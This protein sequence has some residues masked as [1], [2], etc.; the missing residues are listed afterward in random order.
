MDRFQLYING[1]QVEFNTT[2]SPILFQRQRTD[3]TNPTIVKNSFT[4]TVTL[5]GT[6]TN[7]QIFNEIWKLDR[8]QTNRIFNPSKRAPFV[9]IKDGDLIEKGYVKLNKI[10][11]KNNLY[12]Y[13]ITLYG[14]LGNILYEL[15]Y[16]TDPETDETTPMTLGNLSWGFTEFMISKDEVSWAWEKLQNPEMT[17]YDRYLTIN[18][19]VCY[20]GAPSGAKNFDAKAVW[21]SIGEPDIADPE[22]LRFN[23]TRKAAV[24]W[25][26]RNY[27]WGSTDFPGYY[28]EGEGNDRITYTTVYT[29]DRLTQGDYYGLIEVKSE[30]QPLEIRDLRSYL[31]RPVV[32]VS[33]IFDAIGAY[34]LD[35]LGYTLDLS[36]PFFSTREYT[37]TWM[38]LSMLYEIDPEVE[39]GMVFTTEKLFSNTATPADYLISYC[40]TYGIYL[41]VDYKNKTFVLTRLPNFFTGEIRELRIDNS[42]D[43]KITPLSFDKATYT[44][45]FGQSSDGEF[46]KQY[47]DTYGVDFGIKRVNTGYRFDASSAPYIDNNV[48]KSAIDTIEQSPFYKYWNIPGSSLVSYPQALADLANPPKYKL[49][50]T[51]DNEVKTTDGEMIPI[52]HYSSFRDILMY[53]VGYQFITPGWKG[54]RKDIWQDS[55]PR[56]QFH[57]SGNKSIDGKDVLITYNGFQRSQYGEVVVEDNKT[58]WARSS[59]INYEYVHYLLSDDNPVCKGMIGKNAYFDNPEPVNTSHLQVIDNLPVFTR[60]RYVLEPGDRLPVSIFSSFGSLV[61]GHTSNAGTTA[62][63]DEKF[64]TVISSANNTREYGWIDIT[65]RMKNNHKYFIATEIDTEFYNVLHTNGL[66]YPDVIGSILDDY[67]GVQADGKQVIASIVHTDNTGSTLNK[68]ITMSLE[69][70]NSTVYWD[71]FWIMVYDLTEYGLEDY[72]TTAQQGIDYFGLSTESYGYSFSQDDILDFSLSREMFVPACTYM[73][74]VGIY[75]RYWK[76]Y[77]SDVYNVNTRVME[78]YCYL[79]NINEVFKEFYYYDNSLWILSKITDWDGD[80]KK[81]KATFIKVNDKDNYIL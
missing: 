27:I 47:K 14:E 23:G 50:N 63:S 34:M 19:A 72:I 32:K 43:I 42:K 48:F 2:D 15:S 16:Q 80:T 64:T 54:L 81:A 36:D 25:K 10:V 4:K 40:K 46:M 17:G 61:F 77:I 26:D 33:K 28:D 45:N 55:T 75:N 62:V 53:N 30:L 68:L 22:G 38:T 41:D 8:I 76:N 59:G 79:D 60:N 58:R 13:E 6:K 57:S 11:H 35:N 65:G 69:N 71:T 18:F 20:D 24:W 12:T 37:D 44:F 1:R 73:P 49:F 7:S 21:T 52:M 66:D 51:D 39:S 29:G 78:C 5:P 31:L 70:S 9:L 3:Y 74:G 56:L 67:K